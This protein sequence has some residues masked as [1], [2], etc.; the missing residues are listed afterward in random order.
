MAAIRGQMDAAPL[1]SGSAPFSG[2]ARR[3]SFDLTANGEPGN[4]VFLWRVFTEGHS[5]LTTKQ[6]P[7]GYNRVFFRSLPTCFY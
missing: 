3:R 2:W 6:H 1:A 5:E 7:F 4:G